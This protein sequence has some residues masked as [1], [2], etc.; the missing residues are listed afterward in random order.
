MVLE[1][2]PLSVRHSVFTVIHVFE[3]DLRQ[4]ILLLEL[5]DMRIHD[6]PNTADQRIV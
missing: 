3:W 2:R 4:E 5:P 1:P 6:D